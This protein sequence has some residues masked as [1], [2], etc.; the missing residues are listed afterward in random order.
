MSGPPIAVALRATM[1]GQNN[2]AAKHPSHETV[3][4]KNLGARVYN[5]RGF[6]AV[7]DGVTLDTTAVQAA[8]DTCNREKGG[9][10]LEPATS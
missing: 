9:T 2:V 10:V 8:I 5:I 3:D 6:G 1:L 4:D 7:G